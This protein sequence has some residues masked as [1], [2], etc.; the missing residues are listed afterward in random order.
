LIEP[1]A[2]EPCQHY[3]MF[4]EVSRDPKRKRRLLL[5]VQSA[6]LKEA[7]EPR[8]IKGRRV[9]FSTLLK[10]ACTRQRLKG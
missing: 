6:Y 8:L 9:S 4:F 10:A 5:K 2:N 1:G 3:V 7:L